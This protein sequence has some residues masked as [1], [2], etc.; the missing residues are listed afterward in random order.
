MEKYIALAA[1]DEIR[2][3]NNHREDE[4]EPVNP[5]VGNGHIIVQTGHELD[6]IKILDVDFSY[7]FSMDLIF[8]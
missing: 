5:I 7:D 4:E 8:R 6:D 2:I 1:S 3:I